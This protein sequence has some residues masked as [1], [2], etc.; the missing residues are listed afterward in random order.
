MLVTFC[1]EHFTHPNSHACQAR[2]YN[3]A[4]K[5]K[6]IRLT[7]V[8]N[9]SPFK[10][11]TTLRLPPL[12]PRPSKK[13]KAL[14]LCGSGSRCE[15]YLRP[16]GKEKARK[17]EKRRRVLSTRDAEKKE[18]FPRGFRPVWGLLCLLFWLKTCSNNGIPAA[19]RTEWKPGSVF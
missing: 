5:T 2:S 17:E 4:V 1:T 3:N 16:C 13:K 9:L 14:F 10:F 18:L 7:G 12:P 19:P 11:F 15:N 6:R 8:F